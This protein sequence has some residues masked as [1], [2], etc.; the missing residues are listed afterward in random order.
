MTPIE[1]GGVCGSASIRTS[2]T[3]SIVRHIRTTPEKHSHIGKQRAHFSMS[4]QSL[5]IPAANPHHDVRATRGVLSWSFRGSHSLDVSPLRR[6]QCRGGWPL[7]SPL[8][9]SL[10]PITVPVPSVSRRAPAAAP[11]SGCDF[12]PP[13]ETTQGSARV[14]LYTL[15]V[16]EGGVAPARSPSLKAHKALLQVEDLIAY[17]IT[18][19]HTTSR[20]CVIRG[21]IQESKQRSKVFEELIVSQEQLLQL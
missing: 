17:S 6:Q 13:S 2:P 9:L 14:E 11:G 15:R 1:A 12:S 18:P 4:L 19:K 3:Q 7:A 20:E 21:V 10:L 5:Q 16:S 8:H